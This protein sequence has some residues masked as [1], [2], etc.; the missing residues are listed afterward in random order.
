MR[1]AR[2]VRSRLTLATTG[3]VAG[4]LGVGGVLLLTLLQGMLVGQRDDAARRQAR[5]VAA[6]VTSGRLP[7]PVPTSATNVVQVV[8][9]VGRV[10]A[11]SPGGDRL[12]P[13]LEPG[14]L[15]R[16]RAGAAVDLP[17]RRIGSD[18][19]LRVVAVPAGPPSDPQTVLL[20]APVTDLERGLAAV[21][22]AV[23][24][25]VTLLV[26]ASAVLTW[27]L[28]GWALRPVERLTQG[29]AGISGEGSRARLPVPGADDEVRRLAETLNAMLDRVQGS[30]DRQRA[31]L[32]DAAHELR[33][34]L[35]S[36]RTGLEVALLHPRTADWRQ[37]AAEALEDTG[38]MS[39]LV[40]DLLLLARVD[41]TGGT[42]TPGRASPGAD[43]AAVADG[44]VARARATAPD[45]VRV[46]RTGAASA[47]VAVGE[48]TLT[49]I[50]A[51]LVEN[52]TADAR[53]RVTVEVS[54]DGA[55]V[56]LQVCD[57]GPGIP[58]ADRDRVFERFSR[59]DDSRARA[60]GGSGLGLAIVQQLATTARGAVR[61]EDGDP[62]LRA[63]VR[64]PAPVS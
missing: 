4:G 29:A 15:A 52:A 24:V 47:A 63:V 46:N 37:T 50:V 10:R 59:L 45:G 44:V 39:R 61:L 48:D 51:N 28:V 49:R 34:P 2:S 11:A 21:R 35:A 54:R 27:L 25:A 41:E 6:L 7:D 16:A 62:G 19:P 30:A 22:L 17:G 5:D 31:F 60:S 9:A 14:P 53:S 57:D 42:G 64:L 20:A 38:R 26:L 8:D 12:V 3:V 32:S 36:L 23:A 43:L 33:S 58:A 56:V 13:L 40:D 55:D 18:E 1:R